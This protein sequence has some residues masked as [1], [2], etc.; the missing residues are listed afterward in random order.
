MI[1]DSEF[2]SQNLTNN[3]ILHI[4]TKAK[5]PKDING[6]FKKKKAAIIATTNNLKKMGKTKNSESE[7]PDKQNVNQLKSEICELKKT[8]L[9]LKKINEELRS[10]IIIV[11]EET[12]ETTFNS[13]N[14]Q[15]D[16]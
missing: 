11:D 13:E 9:E 16:P 6:L 1:T 3:E 12:M 14:L 2:P 5:N 7:V 15:L 8:I 10:K 4:L